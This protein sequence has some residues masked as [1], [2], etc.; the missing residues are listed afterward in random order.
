ASPAAA[1]GRSLARSAAA[2]A[3]FLVAALVTGVV[4]LPQATVAVEP[5]SAP[6]GPVEVTL[7]AGPG[8]DLDAQ[9]F[10]GNVSARVPGTATGRRTVETKA[11]GTVRFTNKTTNDIALPRGTLVR[12][13]SVRFLTTEA[14][15][16]SRSVLVPFLLATTD[17]V[18]E[19][20]E[21]GRAGNV[22][23]NAISSSDPARYDATNPQPTAGGDS[24]T[25]TIVTQEDYDVAARAVD[26]ALRPAIDQQL[27]A[28]RSQVRQGYAFAG[29]PGSRIVQQ[30]SA[31][32][33]VGK[34]LERFEVL[35]AAAVYT[36]AVP[37]DQPRKA[38]L[39][40]LAAAVEP[41]NQLHAAGAAIDQL[42]LSVAEHGV[43]YRLRVAGRQLVRYSGSAIAAALAGKTPG[44]AEP[45]LRQRGVR[46]V[47]LARFPDWWPRLPLLD[48]RIRIVE[49]AP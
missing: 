22:S 16:L 26:A 11:T 35:V 40:R 25:V 42:G 13:G 30:V 29:A 19:A 7:R 3:S 14:K 36:F 20:E 47:E 43:T 10:A 38:A 8:G 31:A 6:L 45:I 33:L 48:A 1:G 17:I 41:G 24:R 28:W 32:D 44:E 2:A 18:V 39:E 49:I 37:A 9:P 46:L 4:A 5:Q 21:A 23:A 34:E 27:A 15:T 12:A